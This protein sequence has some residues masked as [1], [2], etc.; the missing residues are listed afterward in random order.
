MITFINKTQ[1]LTLWS[2]VVLR[3]LLETISRMNAGSRR[4]Y[5]RSLYRG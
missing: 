2:T 4:V 5:G 1:Q 3:H